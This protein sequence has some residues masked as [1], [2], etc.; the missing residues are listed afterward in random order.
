MT[1]KTQGALTRLRTPNRAPSAPKPKRATENG[2]VP[3]GRILTL[4]APK[5]TRPGE[6]R[7][8][9]MQHFLPR[10]PEPEKV[11]APRLSTLEL[12]KKL[13]L[14]TAIDPSINRAIENVEVASE[15]VNLEL[16]NA[17]H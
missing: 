15:W 4:S 9:T 1:R 5:T 3:D 7:M 10:K 17:S 16:H 2:V 8:V 14:N 12:S 11:T 13:A 6:K